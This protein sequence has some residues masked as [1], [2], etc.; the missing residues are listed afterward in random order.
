MNPRVI[1]DPTAGFITQY[2][3]A[4]GGQ[5]VS[6]TPSATTVA[7][8]RQGLAPDGTVKPSHVHSVATTV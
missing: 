6:Q 3:S 8:L 7:Y 5:I 1:E 4:N 2:L